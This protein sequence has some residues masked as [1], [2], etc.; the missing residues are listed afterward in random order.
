MNKGFHR[1]EHV[2]PLGKNKHENPTFYPTALKIVILFLKSC[3]IRNILVATSWVN[4]GQ[5]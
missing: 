3:A 5:I 4:V 2:T 1:V